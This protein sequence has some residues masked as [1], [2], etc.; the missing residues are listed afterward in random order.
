[1][2]WAQLAG[3]TSDKRRVKR[4]IAALTHTRD[5]LLDSLS[6]LRA[7]A[8]R[9]SHTVHFP[10]GVIVRVNVETNPDGMRQLRI[11]AAVDP[12]ARHHEI[13]RATGSD[14]VREIEAYLATLD[15]RVITDNTFTPQPPPMPPTQPGT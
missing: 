9:D 10:G 7:E 8:I 11:Q 14:P 12:L 4:S 2:W 3:F 1:M 6:S 13:C 5:E 15:N